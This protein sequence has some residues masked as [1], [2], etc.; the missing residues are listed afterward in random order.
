[1]SLELI[2]QNL[3]EGTPGS[4]NFCS[5]K[6][7]K[8]YAYGHLELEIGAEEIFIIDS[9]FV[10]VK[11]EKSDDCYGCLFY[12]PEKTNYASKGKLCSFMTCQYFAREDNENVIFRELHHQPVEKARS[13]LDFL[14]DNSSPEVFARETQDIPEVLEP[15]SLATLPTDLKE[16]DKRIQFKENIPMWVFQE[17]CMGSPA[18]DRFV[19][20]VYFFKKDGLDVVDFEKL[21]NDVISEIIEKVKKLQKL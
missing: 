19:T 21:A 1:M 12:N 3:K 2:K 18:L 10:K 17:L 7:K 9:D 14:K 15:G 4:V 6:C 20:A 13:F 8:F 5:H 16:P 11:T